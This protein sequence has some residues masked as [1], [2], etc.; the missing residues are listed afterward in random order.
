MKHIIYKDDCS[1]IMLDG[2]TLSRVNA[3]Y[4]SATIQCDS[5][6]V[7]AHLLSIF[8]KAFASYVRPLEWSTV[9]YIVDEFAEDKELV[10]QP[11]RQLVFSML[12]AFRCVG[13]SLVDI[14]KE[15][16]IFI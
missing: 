16:F 11:S 9:D 4:P 14:D 2:F 15:R 8:M 1:E 12:L 6:I 10:V 7:S 5:D 3:C 13:L